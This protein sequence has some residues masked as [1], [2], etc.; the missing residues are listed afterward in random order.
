MATKDL[1][2]IIQSEA[3]RQLR[4]FLV[5]HLNDIKNIDNIKEY[6]TIEEQAIEIKSQ[7]RLKAKLEEIF[8]E[9]VDLETSLQPKPNEDKYYQL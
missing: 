7:K 4:E 6:S 2:K 1:K 5:K 9:I 3:G 8:T